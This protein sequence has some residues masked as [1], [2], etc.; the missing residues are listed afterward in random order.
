MEAGWK[1]WAFRDI[2]VFFEPDRNVDL[3]LLVVVSM[4]NKP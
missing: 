1:V 2:L 4:D 3:L